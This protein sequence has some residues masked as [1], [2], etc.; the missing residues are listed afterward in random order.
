MR[1]EISIVVFL[2]LTGGFLRF[3]NLN[4]DSGN[5]LHPDERNIANAVS[6]IHFFDELNPNFF[7]YGGF[8]IY[9]ARAAGDLMA[10]FTGNNSWVAD[11]GQINI[12]TRFL[13]AVFSTLTIIPLY[14]LAKKVAGRET[15]ALS[16]GFYAF[17][18]SSIQAA[19][20]GT[21]ESMLVF[22]VVFLCFLSVRLINKPSMRSYLY[23]GII[24]G[25]A[26][27][28][29]MTALFFIIIP[30][31]A[32]I[33]APYKSHKRFIALLLSTVAVFTLFSPYTFL[34]WDKFVESMRYESAVVTG[35][36]SVPYTLQFT[37]T[38]V[39]LYQIK[40]L[41]WQMG[42]AAF[43]II[44]GIIFLVI[45]AILEKN[46]IAIV[47]I[48]F[49]VLY[50]AYVGLW[51]A[52]FIRYM[53]PIIPFLIITISYFLVLLKKEFLLIGRT[54]IALF[55]LIT[56]FWAI[57]FFS[58]YTREQTRI[59][60]S[61]WIYSNIPFE[62]KILGEHWDDGLPL[63]I[64]P[65]TEE[66]YRRELLTIYEPDNQSKIN[67]YAAQLSTADYIIINSRRLYGTLMYL[68]DKYPVT[69]RYYKLLFDEKLGYK[70]AA[71][72][73]S[74]P[75]LFGITINDDGSEESFQVFEHPKV[76][77]FKNV[78]DKQL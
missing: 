30:L 14:L 21:V 56:I 78:S 74:Y 28:T 55:L 66:K 13:S 17:T 57:S 23:C 40:N 64:P 73:S 63:S 24:L 22:M 69:S 70:K 62:S 20:F 31:T 53:L 15:A 51:Q 65:F 60:A 34:N 75:S 61:K 10:Q 38:A 1:R 50:F 8:P 67:Y 59:T 33:L 77:I 32:H 36:L 19:H 29:K 41:F 71:E 6:H 54:F 44:P 49:P 9:L 26:I 48:I 58:I 46:K 12:I 37:N 68:P 45:K 11:W 42:P 39:Y 76:I 72:F 4:W 25:L 52:K 43:F 35:T 5:L 16:I 18:V 7:A 47:L 3:Y 27:A 2:I